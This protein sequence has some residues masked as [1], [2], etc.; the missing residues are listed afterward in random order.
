MGSPAR[1]RGQGSRMPPIFTVQCDKCDYK[2]GGSSYI[3]VIMPDGKEEI[4]PHPMESQHAESVTMEKWSVLE[5]QGRIRYRNAMFC[6]ECGAVDYYCPARLTH[7]GNVVRTPSLEEAQELLCRSC[8]KD[9]LSPMSW[10]RGCL[11]GLVERMGIIRKIEITCPKCKTGKLH[12][13][14]TAWS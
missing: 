3:A 14:L 10:K 9:A 5:K 4:C 8:G 1:N 6:R 12:S 11:L 2:V 7:S 13:E